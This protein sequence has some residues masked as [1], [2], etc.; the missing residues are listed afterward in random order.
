[1]DGESKPHESIEA[2]AAH[3]IRSIR[4]QQPTG[5]Y[6]LGGYCYGGVVAYEV[7]RQLRVAGD[8]IQLLG[9]FEGYAPLSPEEQGTWWGSPAH[10]LNFLRNIP[11]W[12]AE[13]RQLGSAQ[14]LAR[15][16]RKARNKMKSFGKQMGVENG[17][18][19]R[20]ILDD[21]S[22]VPEA[23]RHVMEAQIRARKHY[24]PPAYDGSVALFRTKA[25]SLFR[26]H[27]PQMGWQ[28]LGKRGV[29]L[30]MIEGGHNNILER[31]YVD[32]LARALRDVLEK[33]EEN[34]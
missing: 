18:E 25:R 6:F 22:E 1:M 9:I 33:A 3:Y 27:D 11:Y 13:Y 32:S 21:E 19:I 5:P 20:D 34:N 10:L 15:V 23:H 16:R 7:A 24:Q 2:M 28:K 26:A 31:P 30:R 8:E 14:M 29:D 17:V 4:E 12:F